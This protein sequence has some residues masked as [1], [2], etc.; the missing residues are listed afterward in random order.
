MRS[1]DLALQYIP[2]I[3]STNAFTG[4]IIDLSLLHQINFMINQKQFGVW[5]DTHH[6]VIVGNDSEED[7]PLTVIAHINVEKIVPNSNEK[8]SNNQEQMLQ[9]KFFKQIATN[10]INATH[11]HVTGTGQV[12]EQFVKY[13][14]ETPQFKNS[15]AVES[16][17][18]KMSDEKLIEYIS[19]KF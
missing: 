17:S 15:K 2:L 12:Q 16:T 8:N 10:M 4:S 3:N 11:I 1:A 7:G 9:A 18:L 19:A 5:M 13:L 6:A 14:A